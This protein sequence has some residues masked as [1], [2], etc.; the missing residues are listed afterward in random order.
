MFFSFLKCE[1]TLSQKNIVYLK[2][3]KNTVSVLKIKIERVIR[4][5]RRNIFSVSQIK[6]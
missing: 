3:V 6:T 2:V 1:A 5:E 4:Q